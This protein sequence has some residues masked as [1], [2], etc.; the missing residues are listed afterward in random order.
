MDQYF[1]QELADITHSL[2]EKASQMFNVNMVSKRG[3]KKNEQHYGMKVD[4]ASFSLCDI[5]L[6]IDPTA[7][8]CFATLT[9]ELLSS[10]PNT[11]I[12]NRQIFPNASFRGILFEH[13]LQFGKD[14]LWVSYTMG[15]VPVKFVQISPD[16]F[17]PKVMKETLG[18]SSIITTLWN[19]HSCKQ[20][21][22]YFYTDLPFGDV[23]SGS[24]DFSA[25]LGWREDPEVFFIAQDRNIT[26]RLD[27]SLR[28]PIYPLLRRHS[29]INKMYELKLVASR[30]L[31][32]P[33]VYTNTSDKS[34]GMAQES[35][36]GFYGN[37]DRTQVEAE[38]K[39]L[40]NQNQMMMAFLTN[41][42]SNNMYKEYY[43][44]NPLGA[45]MNYRLQPL[46]IN[47][48]MVSGPT[49]VGPSDILEHEKSNRDEICAIFGIP[50]QLLYGQSVRL[51]EVT[52]NMNA[53]FHRNIMFHIAWINEIFS[54][55]YNVIYNDT[56]M[57]GQ[58]LNELYYDTSGTETAEVVQ[59]EQM[60]ETSEPEKVGSK[61][62]TATRLKIIY[63]QISKIGVENEAF[64]VKMYLPAAPPMN[65]EELIA[66]YQMGVLSHERMASIALNQ[67]GPTIVPPFPNGIITPKDKKELE[68]RNDE[69]RLKEY[70]D[71]R[72][73]P[74]KKQKINS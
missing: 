67:L 10:I 22:H 69:N 14:L 30:S 17:V 36:Y 29:F 7:Q 56:E 73:E 1:Q 15:I 24:G 53:Q 34:D 26:P 33:V 58:I 42:Q 71:T 2:Q 3:A 25:G 41:V 39:Y 6:S 16:I 59:N 31:A 52:S 35:L 5:F 45:M 51:K 54:R 62:L 40:R 12:L 49:P 63:E 46:P 4:I 37:H 8:A 64:Q 74:K 18:I 60:N 44:D 13:W 27:G 20:E 32:N 50:A 28:S 48:T 47:H 43:K 65:L 57:V 9:R 72:N 23:A 11:Y 66:N 68:S 19:R 70:L 55:L 21:Y 38:D 61:K